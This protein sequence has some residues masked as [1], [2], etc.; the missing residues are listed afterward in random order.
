MNNSD[1]R[2]SAASNKSQ[3][4][5]TSANKDEPA[6]T[7][8]AKAPAPA[9]SQAAKADRAQAPK[10]AETAESSKAP[11]AEKSDPE[12]T[13]QPQGNGIADNAASPSA[14]TTDLVLDPGAAAPVEVKERLSQ[15]IAH[16]VPHHP[17]PEAHNV[18]EVLK[19]PED[20][21][22]GKSPLRHLTDKKTS[23]APDATG[24]GPKAVSGG[25]AGLNNWLDSL[26]EPNLERL[27]D[28]IYAAPS[29]IKKRWHRLRIERA[30]AAELKEQERLLEVARA[31][32]KAEAAK[33]E[34]ARLAHQA[35]LDA[36][37][38]QAEE[39]RLAAQA[40]AD[41]RAAAAEE[42]RLRALAPSPAEAPV[43]DAPELHAG[44]LLSGPAD[45]VVTAGYDAPG[46][47][48]VA[49][50]TGTPVASSPAPPMDPEE[51]AAL[52]ASAKAAIDHQQAAAEEPVYEAPYVLPETGPNPAE[53]PA[54]LRRRILGSGAALA[55]AAVSLASLQTLSSGA[56][57][58]LGSNHSL[59]SLAPTAHLLWPVI[60]IWA[61]LG[62]AYSWAPS[63][64]SA[65]RQRAVGHRFALACTANVL[66]MLSAVNDW[67]FPAFGFAAASCWFLYTAVRALNLKTARTARER[68][69]TDAPVSLMT[70]FSM[71]VLAS[72]FMNMLASW[73]AGGAGIWI[74]TLLVPALGYAAASLSMTE[75]GRIIMAIGFGWGMF[76]LLV[77]RVLGTNNSIWIAI[78]AG[79]AAFVVLLATENRRY[80]I[81]HAEHRAARGKSTDFA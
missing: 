78:L 41:A 56:V 4:P 45:D 14:R 50:G 40:Q 28:R 46:G 44:N 20:T 12:T 25:F 72:T 42:A 32:A 70:G 3:D 10:T 76:W 81:H 39:A 15:R 47:D 26:P 31:E 52:V 67:L 34:A 29:T 24:P 30:R 13:N 57:E 66:W 22:S 65:V 51:L 77:P 17:V 21:P 16:P 49:A 23:A 58:S 63:Q 33:R 61:L 43:D 36:A 75:R 55:A 8:K 79:M 53:E 9:T 27:G 59:L 35:Q 48:I 54:D 1:T 62:A 69:L 68:M 60:F 2:T 71:V 73:G 18:D 19:S 74:A 64:R 37:A 5:A 6:T 7:E 80:Q 38:R 11:E